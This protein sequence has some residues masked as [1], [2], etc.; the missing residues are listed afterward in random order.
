MERCFSWL[1]ALAANH[2]RYYFVPEVLA[3]VFGSLAWVASDRVPPYMLSA[4]RVVPDIV[5]VGS[6]AEVTVTWRAATTGRQCGGTSL[7][8][9]VDRRSRLQLRSY[10][11]HVGE[12]FPD[13]PGDVR[14]YYAI[15]GIPVPTGP[16]DLA[17]GPV[18]VR[19]TNTSY[20]NLLQRLTHA[21]P[22][23]NSSPYAIFE[24]EK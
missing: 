11:A 23:I 22:T 2:Q 3:V 8:E 18:R 10:A 19:V 7:V 9:F 24:I 17:P 1:R 15:R 21:W 14:G 5:R 16:D 13:H 20:C 12:F 4:G 6:R